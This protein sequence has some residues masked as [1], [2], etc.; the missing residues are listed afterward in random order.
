MAYTCASVRYHAPHNTENVDAEAQ[1][2]RR[3]Q[4]GR[5]AQ[6]V[7][8]E[9]AGR[10]AQ[11]A[12]RALA[13][14]QAYAANAETAA[15]TNEKQRATA[16]NWIERNLLTGA[17][18]EYLGK[19]NSRGRTSNL[20]GALL[21]MDHSAYAVDVLGFP[22]ADVYG[23]VA[24]CLETFA[25]EWSDISNAQTNLCSFLL[26]ELQLYN[27]YKNRQM[28]GVSTAPALDSDFVLFLVQSYLKNNAGA[29]AL[30]KASDG[31]GVKLDVEEV[32]A[33]LGGLLAVNVMVPEQGKLRHSKVDKPDDGLLVREQ[34]AKL[35]GGQFMILLA[36]EVVGV[37][38][39]WYACKIT[40]SKSFLT[41]V[42]D[43][44]PYRLH[45]DFIAH[46]PFPDVQE[47]QVLVNS[48][49]VITYESTD[50][51][52][53]TFFRAL[54]VAISV[55]VHSYG[56]DFHLTEA[57]VM[58][59]GLFHRFQA[60]HRKNI[61]SITDVDFMRFVQASRGAADVLS[62]RI[63]VFDKG[64]FSRHFLRQHDDENGLELN[65]FRNGDSDWRAVVDGL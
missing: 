17:C 35:A 21:Y 5:R 19:V 58:L 37:T 28:G 24:H 56:E 52:P 18:S 49:P 64:G 57:G 4:A 9:Q 25:D 11:A 22:H 39:K 23:A 1:A 16:Y 65:L 10:R 38:I 40:Q 31:D 53:L 32:Q 13:K 2:A 6:A 46:V 26:K 43:I 8:R 45:D 27:D 63:S 47:R 15:E 7:R 60:V 61:A 29:A 33:A 42:G 30:R 55:A 51:S 14:A 20:G 36:R 48:V 12:G 54:Y 3:A 50:K 59:T 34:H 44:I 41:R 62:M